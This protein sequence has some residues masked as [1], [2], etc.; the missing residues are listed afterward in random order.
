VNVELKWC[1]MKQTLMYL[2]AFTWRDQE[3]QK[4]ALGEQIPGSKFE[5]GTS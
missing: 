5:T 2:S 3:T 1:A 4:K